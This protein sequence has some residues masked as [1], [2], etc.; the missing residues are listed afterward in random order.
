MVKVLIRTVS[1][2]STKK[3]HPRALTLAF[4]AR[5]TLSR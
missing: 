2:M 1:R 4:S 5:N 3:K